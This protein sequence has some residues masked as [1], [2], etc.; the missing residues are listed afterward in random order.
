MTLFLVAEIYMYCI[1]VHQDNVKE[2]GSVADHDSGFGTS[3]KTKE[4]SVTSDVSVCNI[5]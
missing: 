3:L 1:G 2:D 4:K 5:M